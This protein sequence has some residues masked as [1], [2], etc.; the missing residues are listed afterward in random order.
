MTKST[1]KNYSA[2]QEQ[3]L[4]AVYIPSDSQE[5]REAQVAQLAEELDKKP[6]SIIAKLSRMELYVAKVRTTKAGEPVAH[7]KDIVA[8]IAKAAGLTV[9]QVASFTKATKADLQTFAK[10]TAN[11]TLAN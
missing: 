10:A 1:D 2:D 8:D 7:K 11:K 4:R 3:T 9:E 6:R 5:A